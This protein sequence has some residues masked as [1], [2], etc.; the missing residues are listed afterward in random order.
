MMNFLL[1]VKVDKEKTKKEYLEIKMALED[2]YKKLNG[3]SSITDKDLFI[4]MDTQF[5]VF[6]LIE[7]KEGFLVDANFNPL[8]FRDRDADNFYD[9]A[10]STDTVTDEDLTIYL[11]KRLDNLYQDLICSDM[12]INDAV[13]V[14]CSDAFGREVE[15]KLTN[16]LA[17]RFNTSRLSGY[18]KTI[19]NFDY[20][21]FD[22]DERGNVFDVTFSP[23]V[24]PYSCD[25]NRLQLWFSFIRKTIDEDNTD[26]LRSIL[27]N[28]LVEVVNNKSI[29]LSC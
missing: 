5:E 24:V 25:V 16:Q 26:N 11:C 1:C 10:L 12:A 22:D 15:F 8:E 20:K 13:S 2:F 29:D 4:V 23:F 3:V 17:V 18:K 6:A 19:P 14:V 27:M 7:Y 21:I 9:F 28:A